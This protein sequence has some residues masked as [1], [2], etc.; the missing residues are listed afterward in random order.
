MST[1]FSVTEPEQN[2]HLLEFD[3]G[4]KLFLVGTAHVSQQSCELVERIITDIKPDTVCIELDEQRHRAMTQKAVYENIDII[5]IIKKRQLFFFIG[6]FLLASYQKKISEKTGSRPGLEFEQANKLAVESNARIVLADRNIGITL[7]RAWRL[8]TLGRKFKTFFS[9][10]FADDD[11]IGEKDIEE[12][13][14]SDAIDEMINEFAK[15]LPD[16]KRVLIDERDIYLAHSIQK[17]LGEV[18]VAVLG[19]GHIPGIIENLSRDIPDSEKQK[20]C[21]IPES[22][23]IEKIIPWIIPLIIVGIFAAGFFFGNRKVAGDVLVF[24]I[25]INGILS[26]VGTL[27]AFGHPLTIL[28]AFVGAPITS[29]NPTIGVGIV[30]SFVQTLVCKPRVKDFEEVQNGA[31]KIVRWWK[32]R[33]TRIFLVF[34]LS[35]IGSVIGTWVGLPVLMRILSKG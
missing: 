33:L 4:K 15:E 35:S 3:D 17:N 25:L 7:K 2:V 19:A 27:L 14:Q 1:Q 21:V 9:L 11:K 22:G 5:E 29:L 32:N 34:I 12:L 8:T 13:K 31:L 16:A 20:I 18:T 6:Q 24:W 26:A 10:L 28:A 23:V 30:T